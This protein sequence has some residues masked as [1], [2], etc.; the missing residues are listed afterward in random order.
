MS[1]QPNVICPAC[2]EGNACAPAQSGSLDTPCWCAEI[3]V[4]PA[5]IA[6]LPESER[7]RS[8]LCRRCATSGKA[9]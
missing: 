6:R 7:N 8:C 9:P 4:D 5:A 3:L 2:G 1:A